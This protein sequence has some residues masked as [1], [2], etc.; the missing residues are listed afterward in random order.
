PSSPPAQIGSALPLPSSAA[1]LPA[2]PAA[3]G[4]NLAAPRRPTGMAD[5]TL[6]P[7]AGD[8]AE[9]ARPRKKKTMKSLYLAFFD[10]AADGRSRACRLCGKT[11][12]LTTATGKQAASAHPMAQ[13]PN[14]FFTE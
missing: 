13:K 1:R 2:P 10:T 11:Y 12:C 7:A 8:G 6:L 14:L 9:A 4:S 5:M 3:A